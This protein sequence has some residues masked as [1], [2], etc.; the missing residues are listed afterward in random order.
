M[1]CGILCDPFLGERKQG[2]GGEKE[3]VNAEA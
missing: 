1:Q 3:K 2:E